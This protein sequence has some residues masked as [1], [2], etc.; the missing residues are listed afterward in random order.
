MFI[1]KCLGVHRLSFC[2]LSDPLR[3]KAH[4]TVCSDFQKFNFWKSLE[5]H[6]LFLNCVALILYRY[7]GTYNDFQKCKISAACISK[8]PEMLTTSTEHHSM[9]L[10]AVALI[11]YM[12]MPRHVQ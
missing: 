1:V 11:L 6:S 10:S 5:H 8:Y 3:V 4:D 7:M 12:A 2:A 9:L